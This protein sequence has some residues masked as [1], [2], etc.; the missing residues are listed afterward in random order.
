MVKTYDISDWIYKNWI[1]TG[2][3]RDKVFIE[4]PENGKVYFFKE[5]IERYPSEFWAEIISSKIGQHLG[6]NVLDYNRFH[7][8]MDQRVQ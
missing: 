7:I 8:L 2:G 3:T 1:G 6:F 4:N 5:S